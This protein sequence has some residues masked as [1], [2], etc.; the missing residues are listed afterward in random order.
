MARKKVTVSSWEEALEVVNGK[1]ITYEGVECVI[2]AGVD[3]GIW[4]P[5]S[6]LRLEPTRKGKRSE[7]YQVDRRKL[8]DDFDIEPN[9]ENQATIASQFCVFPR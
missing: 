6:F 1:T 4:G 2:K 5:R 9:S 3:R 8:G 7:A